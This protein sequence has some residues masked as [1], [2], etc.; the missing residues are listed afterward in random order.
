MKFVTNTNN[1]HY[2]EIWNH[3]K[4]SAKRK[5]L[6]TTE[7]GRLAVLIA[8]LEKDHFQNR[9]TSYMI[10]KLACIVYKLTSRHYIYRNAV[11]WGPH[12]YITITKT[13]KF[14]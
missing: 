1:Y 13:S 5:Q 11:V 9:S 4:R 14:I 7:I 12:R 3:L 2:T 8:V 10:R 6:D